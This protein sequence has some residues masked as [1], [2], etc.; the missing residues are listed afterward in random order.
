MSEGS[1][2]F[3]GGAASRPHY[4]RLRKS[5][6]FFD[7]P[8]A[9]VDGMALFHHGLRRFTEDVDIL[10][11]R[12]SLKQIHEKLD[13][14]GYLPP[15]ARSKHLRDVENGVKIEFLTTGN[16]PG[17]GKPKPV[18]FP[19]PLNV[20]FETDGIR[21]VKLPTL[22][23]LKLASGMTNP[24]R[25]KDLADV[26]ELIK[27]LD[28]P[29]EFAEGLDLSV[30]GEYQK[31]W[32]QARKRFVLMWRNKRLTSRSTSIEEMA[33]T[34][35]QATETLEA[36]KADGVFLDPDG[37]TSDDFAQL[38][39]ISPTI[40]AKYGFH[41]EGKVWDEVEDGGDEPDDSKASAERSS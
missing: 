28:L 15:F 29:L 26:L 18:G 22:V 30:R 31:L 33:A 1:E 21:Y 7:I 39:T 36:M 25:M 12:E 14:L 4:A 8:Y 24:G 11:T 34:L 20:S 23:E 2:F 40:A 37:A 17:D 6:I 10:V 5:S 3:G 35:R 9:V 19:D 38:V 13:G 41:E 27:A 32:R 16:F